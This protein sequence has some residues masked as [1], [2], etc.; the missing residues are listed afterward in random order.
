[1]RAKRVKVN[2]VSIDYGI[3]VPPERNAA[4]SFL[5]AAIANEMKEGGSYLIATPEKP[6]TVL[7]ARA[8]CS[9][10][11][12]R[13]FA[14]IMRKRTAAEERSLRSKPDFVAIRVWA[15]AKPK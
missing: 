11:R 14:P 2:G 13:D 4:N 1:M 12:K 3:P 6:L 9:A 8:L 7:R 10:L 5:A 15:E